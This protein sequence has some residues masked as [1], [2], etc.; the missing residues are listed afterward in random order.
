MRLKKTRGALI[1]WL[2]GHNVTVTAK[3]LTRHG[4]HGSL[5]QAKT[6]CQR[7][8]SRSSTE[9]ISVLSSQEKS[10]NESRGFRLV[11]HPQHAGNQTSDLV[12]LAF[13]GHLGPETLKLSAPQRGFA[14]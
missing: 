13:L 11:N 10:L 7:T 9:S 8:G 3:N 5:S 2:P 14:L 1:L 6:T 12:Q 4:R